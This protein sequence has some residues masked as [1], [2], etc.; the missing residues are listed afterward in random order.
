MPGKSKGA[1][2]ASVRNR[3]N[4]GVQRRG[5]GHVQR[6]DA[7]PEVIT[8]MRHA[9]LPLFRRRFELAVLLF[10]I[11]ITTCLSVILPCYYRVGPLYTMCAA[12][13]MISSILLS[14]IFREHQRRVNDHTSMTMWMEHEV[15]LP[16]SQRRVPVM[17]Q[18]KILAHLGPC[19]CNM[20]CAK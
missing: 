1:K 13:G 8:R 9:A 18:L 17:L 12:L 19:D 6:P 11:Q 7:L 15:M 14:Y 4:R 10:F 3:H 2:M 16:R 5:R 20:G